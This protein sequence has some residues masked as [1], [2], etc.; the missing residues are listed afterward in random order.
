MV[1]QAEAVRRALA[2]DVEPWG[3]LEG[4]T[5]QAFEAFATYRDMDATE[6]SLSKTARALSK[7]KPLMSGWSRKHSWVRR[8]RAWDDHRDAEMREAEI[9]ERR[10]M[11]KRHAQQARSF[12]RLLMEPALALGKKLQDGE[13]TKEFRAKIAKMDPADILA[14]M[15]ASATAF[16]SLMRAE[17]LAMGESTESVEGR[18]SVHEVK[19][20]AARIAARAAKYIPPEKLDAFLNDLKADLANQ[21]GE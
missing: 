18:I 15:R 13:Y 14:L 12:G 1:T 16:P 19:A 6:R 20:V 3:R 11:G 10:K 7:S 2:V 9:A 8:A 21:L 4:E 5:E 17:R